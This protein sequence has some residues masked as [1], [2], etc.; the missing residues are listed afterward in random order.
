MKKPYK[1]PKLATYGN[2]AQMT[3]GMMG[4]IKM[5]GARKQRT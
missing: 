3:L 1:R 4:G 2:L 5:E